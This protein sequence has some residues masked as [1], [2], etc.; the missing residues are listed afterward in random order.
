MTN[1][2]RAKNIPLPLRDVLIYDSV[3]QI[4]KFQGLTNFV[5]SIH[6][7]ENKFKQQKKAM[8]WLELKDTI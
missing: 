2:L 4:N 3:F 5:A 1:T 7:L 8:L 6:L